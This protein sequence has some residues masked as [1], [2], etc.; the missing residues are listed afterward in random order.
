[1]GVVVVLQTIKIINDFSEPTGMY[2]RRV[3]KTT[4]TP[5]GLLQKLAAKKKQPKGFSLPEILITLFIIAMLAALTIPS[6]KTIIKKSHAETTSAELIRVINLASEAAMTS[7]TT[8]TL[9]GSINHATCV[10]NSW[11]TMI[12]FRDKKA[13]AISADKDTLLYIIDDLQ[14][15]KLFWR[16][17]L[18]RPYLQWQA[19]GATRGENGT[20]WYCLAAEKT[21]RWAIK[22]SQTG[23][24]R[25][26]AD[27]SVLGQLKC[28]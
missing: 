4:A 21:P 9:C 8:V 24:A 19:D 14:Q 27:E 26:E 18:S 6:Y 7:G 5:T 10:V 15:G 25:L 3:C 11:N 28:L 16:S 12:L 23:R 22:I 20:F 1:V 17:S 13:T 2:S